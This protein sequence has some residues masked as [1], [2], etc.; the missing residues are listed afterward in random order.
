MT[1][2]AGTKSGSKDIE[3]S[4]QTPA[5]SAWLPRCPSRV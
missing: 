1:A 2:D 4:P 5:N 3:A